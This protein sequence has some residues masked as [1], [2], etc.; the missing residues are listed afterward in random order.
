MQV[1]ALDESS[2]ESAL[3]SRN[4]EARR[5]AVQLRRALSAQS[6]GMGGTERREWEA[7]LALAEASA[8]ARLEAAEAAMHARYALLTEEA[9]LLRSQLDE[10]R[11]HGAGVGEKALERARASL[12]AERAARAIDSAVSEERR[13]EEVSRCEAAV[14][15]AEMLATELRAEQRRW[16]EESASAR[17]QVLA[18]Q[19]TAARSAAAAAEAGARVRSSLHHLG[20]LALRWRAASALRRS[21]ESWRHLVHSA[22]LLREGRAS[23]AREVQFAT[24]ELK[25]AAHAAAEQA[26]A[27]R[28]A[29]ANRIADLEAQ[30][31]SQADGLAHSATVWSYTPLQGGLAPEAAARVEGR[32]VELPAPRVG[33]RAWA[34]AAAWNERSASVDWPAD[35]RQRPSDPF[36]FLHSRVG[37]D[38]VA[39]PPVRVKMDHQKAAE[40]QHGRRGRLP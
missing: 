29:A 17:R 39:S 4:V 5:L 3:K 18:A 14:S 22:I 33:A 7:R 32:S 26:A 20:S 12:A 2:D 34:T 36:S 13:R 1:A 15:R 6:R 10:A 27:E 37:R 19:E 23:V 35:P 8:A 9:G 21:F 16:L 30:I 38:M 11:T 28:A 40:R 31:W 24:A 25:A